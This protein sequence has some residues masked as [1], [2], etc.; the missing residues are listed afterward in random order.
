MSLRSFLQETEKKQKAVHIS[1]R[2]SPRFEIS[3]IMKAFDHDS[4][5]LLFDNVE[6]YETKVVANVCGTR[7]RLCKALDV[8]KENLYR[9]LTEAWCS[10]TKPK[11][12]EDCPVKEVVEKPQLSKIPILTHFEKDA[13]PYITSAIVSARS[14]DKKVENVS[15]H[16][17]Q[18]LDDKRLAI[19]L[20]PRQLYKLW[21]MTKEAKKD[22]EVAIS[23]GLHPAISMAATSPVSFGVSEYEIANTLLKGNFSLVK[24]KHVDVYAPAE[25]EYVFEG[26][27]ST[28]EEVLEGPL[29]DIT[30]TYDA[31]RSQ[32]VIELVGVMRRNDAV[33]QALLPSGSEH[34]LLM[35]LPREV[36]IWEAAA[37]T[38]PKV[39]AVNL[40]YGGCG[41]LHAIVSIEKQKDGDAKNV[42]MATFG[43]HPSLKHAVVVDADV[44]VYNLVEVEW[45]IATRF[46]A[47]EDL[48]TIPSARGSTLDPSANQES[49]KTTKMG[50]DATR[51]LD[52]RREKFELAK[53]PT[54]G[55]VKRIIDELCRVLE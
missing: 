9:H 47:N 14:P 12:V 25:A 2:V 8:E 21:S 49:G 27:M 51:P 39:K 7:E 6:N 41:W 29:V 31:Q 43:A 38:V 11:T 52:R 10:P 55:R 13:G 50:I 53:I 4:P 35:G 54:E 16:R 23:I 15:I 45:A 30:G 19:R 28:E 37:N 24:C 22:L 44:D 32:P 18:V 46:Q 48:I 40:S 17:L 42:L 3:S 36:K 26:V 34:K 1:E 33:Y 20:V 5:V